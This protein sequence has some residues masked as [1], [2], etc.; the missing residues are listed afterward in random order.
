[1]D[2]FNGAVIAIIA[3]NGWWRRRV[4]ALELE[5][6]TRIAEL[7]RLGHQSALE[8]RRSRKQSSTA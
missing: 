7:T 2:S 8:I 4:R 3:L 6:E 1:V 5:C